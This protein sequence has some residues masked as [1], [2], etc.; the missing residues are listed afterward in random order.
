MNNCFITSMQIEKV[1]HL[2]NIYIPLSS[3]EKKHLI[4]TGKN[5]SGKTSVLESMMHYLS[6]A[7]TSDRLE[8]AQWFLSKHTQELSNLQSKGVINADLLNAENAV[9]NYTAELSRIKSGISISF[10][11][12][13]DTLR[14]YYE[15]GQFILAYYRAERVF[16]AKVP[17]HVEKV[18][19]KEKYGIIEHPRE[20]FVKYLL[21]LRVTEAL[22]RNNKKKWKS[23]FDKSV[24]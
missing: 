6:A 4:F 19:L 5:G 16:S 20:E 17:E 3:S 18:K 12:N 13:A 21:D 1:R 22:A 23:G 24:V 9:V 15:K 14:Y 10:N 8:K 7:A 2:D 11:T